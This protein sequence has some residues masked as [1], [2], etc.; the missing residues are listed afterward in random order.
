M[1]KTD[2]EKLNLLLCSFFA[3]VTFTLYAPCAIYLAN[4]EEFL[5]TL[6]HFVWIPPVCFLAVSALLYFLGSLFRKGRNIWCGILFA[7][8]ILVYLQGN[9]LFEDTGV[10][11][12]MPYHAEEHLGHIV[13]DSAI[14]VIVTAICIFCA[15]KYGNPAGKAFSRISGFFSAFILIAL[16]VLIASADRSYLR[17][18]N[19]FISNEGLLK[20]NA[21]KNVIVLVLDMFDKT[22]MDEILA[23]SPDTSEEFP[24]FVYYRGVEGCYTSTK[25][26]L[27]AFLNSPELTDA[28]SGNGFSTGIY[29]DV[30]FLP[31]K[32]RNETE[33]FLYGSGRIN[34][35]PR[36]IQT[37][38][39][40]VSCSYAPDLFR[41]AVWLYGNEFDAL[42]SADDDSSEVYS[43]SNTDFF[44]RLNSEGAVLSDIPC[45]RMIHLYGSHY[46]YV[47]DEYLNP[48][49]P[50]FSDENAIRASKGA[51]LIADKYLKQLKELRAYENS[52]IVIMADH[53]Y[54]APGLVTDPL[55][56][57]KAPG[58][59]RGFQ[60]DDTPFSQSDIPGRIAGQFPK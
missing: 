22:Y 38:Y 33:N 57:I 52:L 43:I 1:K 4:A 21:G 17:P 14:W 29:T 60:I 35:V 55:L 32:L 50:S 27:G 9:L 24:G 59:D 18:R 44:N 20:A 25:E 28:I 34:D 56:M 37:L 39:R 49:T 54:T 6:Y 13:A 58:A 36:F 10:F 40:L 2:S 12:G 23:E 15:W 51:L 42:Y 3:A 7:V 46:P 16:A 31:E 8:G 11:N 30:R 41:P 53:G 19:G 48:I 5:F 45:F 26:S 47:H